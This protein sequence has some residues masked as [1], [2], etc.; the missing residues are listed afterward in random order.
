MSQ[1]KTPFYVG[2]PDP[3]YQILKN[4]IGVD[5]DTQFLSTRTIEPTSA[6]SLTQVG[7]TS[8]Y[9]L[10]GKTIDFDF[11][12]SPSALID[13]DKSTLECRMKF[14][15]AAG[16]AV[17]LSSVSPWNLIFYFF[18]E[19]HLQINGT[20][21]LDKTAG[22]YFACQTMKLLSEYS[23]DE[24]NAS[25]SVFA[26]IGDK[27]YQ[28]KLA[29]ATEVSSTASINTLIRNEN[30]IP[31]AYG[32]EIVKQ[33]TLKD[34][35]FSIPGLSSNIRTIKISFKLRSSIPLAFELNTGDGYV[36]P[37]SFK[38]H[39][40]EYNFAPTVGIT[41]L[42]DK[43]GASDEHIS[44]IDVDNRKLTFSSDMTVTNVKDVQWIG[45]AQMSNEVTN[46][47]GTVSSGYQNCGQLMLMNGYSVGEPTYEYYL[48]RSDKDNNYNCYAPPSS[49]Q[50]QYAGMMYPYSAIRTQNPGNTSV[51]EASELYREYV[52]TFKE[53]N[54]SK[55][56]PP[57]E[58]AVFKTTMPFLMVKTNPNIKLIQNSDIVIRAPGAEDS[59]SNTGSKSI[60]IFYGKLKS[61][62][63]A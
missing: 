1:E 57:V 34:L 29:S 22:D 10:L 61:F 47:Y 56:I 48:K 21:V 36:H 13:W 42:K 26:P 54:G 46:I 24:I 39:L 30:W 20:N 5:V 33:P 62:N 35:F 50:V 9:N 43:I 44:F 32:N 52:R 49:L 12:V 3:K 18:E 59:S 60:R 41:N 40:H 23:L 37:H 45:M 53:L 17:P 7:A 14:T 58:E 38:I 19:M 6:L 16:N 28:T 31:G 55:A 63:I 25:Q 11:N 4:P 15:K 8:T 27:L 51:L 2:K